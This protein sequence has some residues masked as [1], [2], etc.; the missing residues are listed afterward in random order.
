MRLID[1]HCHLESDA[2]RNNLDSIL[3]EARQAGLVGLITASIVPEQWA[4]SRSLAQQYPEVQ[5]AM[6]VHPWYVKPEHLAMLDQIEQAREQGACAIG[7]IGLDRKVD[8]PE[9]DLQYRAFYR[10]ITLAKELAIPVVLHCRGAFEDLLR[11]LKKLGTLPGGGIVHNFSGSAELVREVTRFGLKISLGGVLTYRNSRKKQDVIRAAYPH[12]LVLE[13]DSPD[14]PPR[15][16]PE[17]P[18]V[19]ANIRHVLRAASEM[20]QL[21]EDTLAEQTTQNAL[22]LFAPNTKWDLPAPCIR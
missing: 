12:H 21:S 1:A 16:A 8:T 20:L 6:G 19:P 17:R 3:D 7:E 4:V 13:T 11:T 14:I 10:Q 18:N 22:A 5:Y 15:E 2:F 9:Y